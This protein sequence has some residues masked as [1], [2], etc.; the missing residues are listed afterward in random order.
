[1]KS[2]YKTKIHNFPEIKPDDLRSSIVDDLSNKF[3]QNNISRRNRGI[4]KQTQP[5]PKQKAQNKDLEIERLVGQSYEHGYSTGFKDG[6]LEDKKRIDSLASTVSEMLSNLEKF[7]KQLLEQTEESILKLALALTRKIIFKEPFIT[8]KVLLKIIRNALSRI[9][10]PAGL[11]IKINQEDLNILNENKKSLEDII[12][13]RTDV[14]IESDT[15]IL[16]GGCIIETDFGEIDARI[17]AQLEVM[18]K[19]L[20]NEFNL[21]MQKKQGDTWK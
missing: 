12:G 15:T 10:D 6:C 4:E 21:I 1:L 2:N 20:L 17:E 5:W 3:E 13:T 16:K 9:V 18:E 14:I 19:A 11:K 7:K 8:E